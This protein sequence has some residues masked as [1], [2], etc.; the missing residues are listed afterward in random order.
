M[1][2]DLGANWDCYALP[3]CLCSKSPISLRYMNT[4]FIL[5]VSLTFELRCSIEVL[6]IPLELL[7]MP[8]LH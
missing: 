8:F 4:R 1:N 5:G 6:S 7:P 3:K 2:V